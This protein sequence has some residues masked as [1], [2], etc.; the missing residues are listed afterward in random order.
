M[1]NNQEKPKFGQSDW[2][3]ALFTAAVVVGWC[4][5][6]CQKQRT[7]E[8]KLK[9]S[10]STHAFPQHLLEAG[11]RKENFTLLLRK[12]KMFGSD[13]EEQWIALQSEQQA[14]WESG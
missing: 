2:K 3:R 14:E 6:C 1:N 9:I 11:A 4:E 5:S 10:T 7:T 8:G 12:E 13:D